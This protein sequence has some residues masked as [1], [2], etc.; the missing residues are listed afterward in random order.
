MQ[1]WIQSWLRSWLSY[2]SM[3]QL[4]QQFMVNASGLL[5]LR[6]FFIIGSVSTEGLKF[7]LNFR[8]SDRWRARKDIGL[9]EIG[10]EDPAADSGESIH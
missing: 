9:S 7:I 4:M 2:L 6:K 8:S 1:V 3:I 5:G 10:F